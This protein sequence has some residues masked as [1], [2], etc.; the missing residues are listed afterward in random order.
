MIGIFMGGIE[1]NISVT[2]TVT[3]KKV[4]ISTSDLENSAVALHVGL[5]SLNE[6][7]IDLNNST[8]IT[9][10]KTAEAVLIEARD[11]MARL[12]FT[13]HAIINENSRLKA[14]LNRISN[15]GVIKNG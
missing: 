13:T 11:L 7:M 10:A 3:E 5:K 2:E 14:E 9:K 1:S 15:I 6:K 8:I 4:D 12:V